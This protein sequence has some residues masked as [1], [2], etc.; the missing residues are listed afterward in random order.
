MHAPWSSYRPIGKGG[1]DPT[2]RGQAGPGSRIR[3]PCG[4]PGSAPGGG[5]TL[6]YALPLQHPSSVPG[7]R[8]STPP[9][10]PA[11][12]FPACPDPPVFRAPWVGGFEGASQEDGIGRRVDMVRAT[13]HDRQ[14][15]EDYALVRSVGMGGVRESLP[16]YRMEPRPGVY[17][18]GA[19]AP[20][21]QAAAAWDLQLLVTLCHYGW[22]QDLTPFSP[23][24]PRRLAAFARAVATCMRDEGGEACVYTP[25]NE[26]SFLTWAVCHSNLVRAPGGA[27]AN[28]DHLLKRR[29]VEAHMAA[30]EAI[31][32]V[33]PANRILT[34]DPVIHVAPSP[35]HPGVAGDARRIN[36][37]QF[38]AWDLL[39]G[40]REPEL[41]GT[42]RYLGLPGVNHYH[43][44]QWVHPTGER[45]HWHRAD[46]RRRP[47]HL[48]LERVHRRYGTPVCI[49]ETSHVGVGRA[50]WLREVARE[51]GRALDRGVP[52]EGICL[53]PVVD[54]PDWMDSTRFH[55]SGLWD[56]RRDSGGVLRR[57]ADPPSL[58]ALH[59]AQQGLCHQWAGAGPAIPELHHVG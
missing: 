19:L 51:V 4:I 13:Q 49:G 52:V 59:H 41:G 24:F 43:G 47:L 32:E 38:E 55:N 45:L 58:T 33:D 31:L 46:R 56:L 48:L 20:M 35:D 40:R 22:P 26:I 14:M 8:S 23:T 34:V 12:T 39:C 7:D 57:V 37:S 17:R 54:R 5:A 3:A 2:R 50:A 28:R 27:G 15:M 11:L 29:L 53:Y 25:V 30:T 36:E 1:H 44:N 10:H 9:E 18:L 21:I 6:A 42:P 16:W